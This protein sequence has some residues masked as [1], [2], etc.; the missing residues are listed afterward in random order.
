VALTRQGKYWHYCFSIRGKRYRGTTK[1]TK[2]AAAAHVESLK[3]QQAQDTGIASLLGR[4]HTLREISSRF[5]EVVK[6]SRLAPKTKKYYNNG[7]RLLEMTH[8]ADMR[9]DN[10]TRDELTALR[11]TGGPSNANNAFRVARLMLGKAREW[12]MVGAIPRVKLAKEKR[13]S[14]MIGPVEEEALLKV[15]KP[16]LRD[17]LI[18]IDD[19]GMRPEEIFRMR[20]D[21]ID[22]R[23]MFYRNPDGKTDEARRFI[24]LTDRMLEILKRRMD[25]E[26]P[27]VFPS[28]RSASGHLTTI[29]KQFQAAREAANLPDDLVFYCGKHG[30]CTD[31]MRRTGNVFALMKAVG[32]KDVKHTMQYQHQGIEQ[33][34]EVVNQRNSGQE[35]SQGRQRPI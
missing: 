8:V 35:N 34:R 28:K 7:W 23:G 4:S 3:R 30:F 32:H 27:W 19:S 12:G 20:K 22:W 13:R 9:L 11:F 2:P 15:A 5:L 6:A 29:A 25:G 21:L 17:T 1:Q 31:V 10:I 18:L 33:V 16:S 24:P 26:S 14:R